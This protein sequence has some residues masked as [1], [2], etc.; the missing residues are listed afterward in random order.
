MT[1]HPYFFLH[2][3]EVFG[4]CFCDDFST[5]FPTHHGNHTHITESLRCL[6]TSIL[7]FEKACMEFD[8]LNLKPTFKILWGVPGRSNAINIA[9]RLELPC[10]II[11]SARGLYGSASAEINEIILD[12]KRYKQ[13]YQRLLNE[14]H[15][16]IR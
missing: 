2:K 9:E 3:N 16:Y 15:R 14:S 10:D 4:M 11:N 13:D 1:L 8:D 12:M 6:N 5:R 7:A